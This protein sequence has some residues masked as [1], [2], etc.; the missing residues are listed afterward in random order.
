[1]SIEYNNYEIIMDKKDSKST[2]PQLINQSVD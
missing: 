2:F 1:M